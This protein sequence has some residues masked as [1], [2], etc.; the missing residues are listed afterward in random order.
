[1]YAAGAIQ[2]EI[3]SLLLR[4]GADVNIKSKKLDVTRVRDLFWNL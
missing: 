3:V 2:L 1:M 4:A